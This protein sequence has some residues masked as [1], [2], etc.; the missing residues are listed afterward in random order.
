VI[1]GEY[2]GV[3]IKSS[4]IVFVMDISKSME[5]AAKEEPAAPPPDKVST[6]TE[7]KE[8]VTGAGS[9]G[10]PAGS[11]ANRGKPV[12]NS[13][14]PKIPPELKN[15]KKDID[16]RSVKK[17]IDSVKKELVN[18]IYGLDDKVYFSIVFYNSAVS[19]WKPEL[20]PATNENKMAAISAIEKLTPSGRTNIYDALEAA[21]KIVGSAALTKNEPKRVT[22]GG[23][24]GSPSENISGADT[25]FLLTDG[26]PNIG[27]IPEPQAIVDAVRKLNETRKIKINTIA[28]G[29]PDPDNPD[30]MSKG[31]TPNTSLMSQLAQ[32]TG[33]TFVDK[34]K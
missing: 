8:V 12:D 28:V 33:G 1:K 29:V 7:K 10:E 31:D 3:K 32:I 11:P 30:P 5:W 27:K 19:V 13:T 25:I 26:N 16:S 15:K 17:R 24:K 23:G 20:V 18:A 6:D 14:S 9:D 21:Y 4:R 34:T 2:Y 22:T